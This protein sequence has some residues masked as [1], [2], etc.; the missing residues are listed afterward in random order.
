MQQPSPRVPG[1]LQAERAVAGQHAA[2]NL[3]AKIARPA[4]RRHGV[5]THQRMGDGLGLDEGLRHDAAEQVALFV[6]PQLVGLV[7]TDNGSRRH[8]VRM[9]VVAASRI[10]FAAVT[11]A[12]QHGQAFGQCGVDNLLVL[13]LARA[14]GIG[15]HD[16]ARP[17]QRLRI[18]HLRGQLHG[19]LDMHAGGKAVAFA[20]T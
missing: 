18:H 8:Q 16:P 2:F 9:G 5:R 1:I 10:V 3:G 4:D 7:Q 6:Q 15:Q 13:G 17:L 20:S 19:L 11:Q 14:I 12:Q